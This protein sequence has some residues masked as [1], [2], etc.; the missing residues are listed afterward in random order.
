[1]HYVEALPIIDAVGF[2]GHILL[3]H[4]FPD[5]WYGWRHQLA[6]LA[7]Q[8]FHVLAPDSRGYGE[9]IPVFRDQ[10]QYRMELLCQV[11]FFL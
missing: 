9:T 7:K 4:G 5:S 10:E 2:R 11:H 6:Y 1:M 3:V 8:G